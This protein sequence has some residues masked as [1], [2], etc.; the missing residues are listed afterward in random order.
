M[1]CTEHTCR[2]YRMPQPKPAPW[3]RMCPAVEQMR[4]SILAADLL[5]TFVVYYHMQS[6]TGTQYVVQGYQIGT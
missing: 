2:T 4:M 6:K 3:M 1:L 5:T